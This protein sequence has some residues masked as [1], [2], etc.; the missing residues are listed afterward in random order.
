MP[1]KWEQLSRKPRE[2]SIMFHQDWLNSLITWLFS[3][4]LC[5]IIVCSNY[6][7]VSAWF[8][9]MKCF[10]ATTILFLHCFYLSHKMESYHNLMSWNFSQGW[11]NQPLRINLNYMNKVGFICMCINSFACPKKSYLK[12]VGKLNLINTVEAC[13]IVKWLDIV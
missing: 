11:N 5:E 12:N 13:N 3:T 4:C 7:Q 2:I 6:N 10:H 1:C 8:T 9:V